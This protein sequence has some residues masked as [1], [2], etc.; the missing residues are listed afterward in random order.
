METWGRSFLRLSDKEYR[1]G[2]TP[3]KLFK[4]IDAWKEVTKMTAYY[5][6]LAYHG[7]EIPDGKPKKVHEVSTAAFGVM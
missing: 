4:M 2:T 5:N 3:R 6:A 7:K 1:W